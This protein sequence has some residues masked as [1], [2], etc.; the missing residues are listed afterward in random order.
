MF[1]CLGLGY[2]LWWIFPVIMILFCF[3]MM[4]TMSGAGCRMPG[5]GKTHG[6][7]EPYGE[8]EIKDR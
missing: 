4:R 8:A 5:G 2:G 1:T 6:P 7:A 3:F